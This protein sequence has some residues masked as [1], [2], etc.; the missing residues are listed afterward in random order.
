MSGTA[1]QF[2]NDLERAVFTAVY[3]SRQQQRLRAIALALFLFQHLLRGIFI[4]LFFS[5]ALLG[6]LFHAPQ[7]G[8]IFYLMVLLPGAAGWVIVMLR[9]VR[10][11][12]R[13]R[14]KGKILK[15]GALRRLW[16]DDAD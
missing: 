14:V 11:D 13:T 5:L 12:Y 6:A 2:R 16:Q 10:H 15:P 8:R 4:A 3:Q 1:T 9:G 7:G